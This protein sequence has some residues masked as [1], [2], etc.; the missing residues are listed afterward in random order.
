MIGQIEGLKIDQELAGSVIRATTEG[1]AMTG[2]EP[3]A[4]GAS[5]FSIVPRDISVLVGL[6]GNR[7]GNLTLNMSKNT[8]T[9]IAGRLLMDES[10]T[11]LDEDAIDGVCEIGNMVAGRMKEI[12]LESNFAFETISLP[13][14]IFGS[15]YHLY[16]LKNI[17]TVSVAFEIPEVSVVN[18][19]D[20]FFSTTLALMGT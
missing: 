11:E 5:R 10:M 14:I 8:A 6:H 17:V 20:K 7:N 1:L 3:D 15:N 4:V 16:N 2:I 19:K 13:A 9:F 12:L 18:M